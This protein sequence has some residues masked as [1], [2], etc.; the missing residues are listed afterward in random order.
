[1]QI[2]ENALVDFFEVLGKCHA[3]KPSYK[4]HKEKAT[5]TGKIIVGGHIGTINLNQAVEY[6]ISD[7]QG[8][9]FGFGL[10]YFILNSNKRISFYSEIQA[11]KDKNE[12]GRLKGPYNY[13][14]AIGYEA[15]QQPW[16]QSELQRVRLRRP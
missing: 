16:A 4:L 10:D 2:Q 14:T 7:I 5:V 15:W 9:N 8:S 11:Y 3:T 12:D 13:E 6:Y 1:M